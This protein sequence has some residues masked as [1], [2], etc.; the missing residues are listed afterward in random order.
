MVMIGPAIIVCRA[1]EMQDGPRDAL[2]RP[3][4][5]PRHLL[6]AEAHPP[7]RRKPVGRE[8]QPRSNDPDSN[9]GREGLPQT[10]G[11][12][13]EGQLREAVRQV[14]GPQFAGEGVPEEEDPRVSPPLPQQRQQRLRQQERTAEVDGED[15]VPRGGGDFAGRRPGKDGGVVDQQVQTPELPAQPVREPSE[16]RRPGQV[17]W[18]GAPADPRCQRLSFDGRGP[19]CQD[20]LVAG[21]REGAGDRR[22]NPPA[23]AGDQRNLSPRISP[24][25]YCG[26]GYGHVYCV[27]PLIPQG[28]G[29]PQ[30]A[31]RVPGVGRSIGLLAVVSTTPPGPSVARLVS[32]HLHHLATN[33]GE[34]RSGTRHQ[35]WTN[36]SRGAPQ[37][38]QEAGGSSP[39]WM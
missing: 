29:Y 20:D 37:M 34:K 6:R 8:D 33:P 31:R 9:P 7:P 35:I 15:G 13:R 18:N 21:L 32:A 39:W 22:A 1:C 4:P 27:V 25:F 23:P 24:G 16:R 38:G 19:V 3:D 5:A 12:G 28:T 2:G 17:E 30:G 11:Q 26:G 36:F 14:T 10:G